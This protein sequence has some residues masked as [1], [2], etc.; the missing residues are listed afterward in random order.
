M[1][2][3]RAATETLDRVVALVGSAAVTESEVIAEYRLETFLSDGRVPSRP[4]DPAVFDRVESR[5]IDQ[6]LLETQLDAYPVDSK[7]IQ[8]RAAEQ[9]TQFRKKV[10]TAAYFQASLQE[11][12]IGHADLLKRLEEQQRI[13]S[14]IDK[15]LRPAAAVT[16]QEIESYYQKTFLPDFKNRSRGA[17][18]A[19]GEVQSR[20]REVLTQEKINQ[21][22]QGWLS[23]LKK[24]EQVQVLSP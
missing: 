2:Q 22:L 17:P 10:K 12:G 11:L 6:K 9:M 8:Q 3:R 18:P 21:L 20:I 13:L 24:D 15:H 5:L 4:P 16:Q 23:E 19:L 1:G 7:S 14:M